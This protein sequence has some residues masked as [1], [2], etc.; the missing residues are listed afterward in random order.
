MAIDQGFANFTAEGFDGGLV[1]RFPAHR[2]G[3]NQSPDAQNF[4]PTEV[5]CVKKRKGF[6]KFTSASTTGNFISG[7]Y[8]ATTSAG[9]TKILASYGTTLDDITAGAFGTAVSGVTITSDA[10]VS[11]KMFND[12]FIIANT[13]GGPYKWSGS[14]SASSLGGSPP[15]N[16]KYGEVH[17]GRFWLSGPGYDYS[18]AA[19]D[20]SRVNGSGLNN[21]ELW[22]TTSNPDNCVSIGFNKGDGYV[23]NG[24]CSAG[25]FMLVSKISNVSG[26][27]EGAIYS[28]FGSS[29]F[30][31]VTKKILSYPALSNTAML[32]YDNFVV[33]ATPKGVFGINGRNPVRMD[34]PIWPTYDAI[35]NKGTIA[36]G[37][38]KKTIRMAYPTSGTTNNAEL[39]LDVERGVWGK[40]TGKAIRVYGNHPDGRLLSGKAGSNV[41]VWEEENGTTDDSAA[42]NFYWETPDIDFGEANEQKRLHSIFTH[43]KNTGSISLAVEQYGDGTSRSLGATMNVSTEGPVKRHEADATPA[44]YHRIRVTNNAASEDVT[45]YRVEAYAEPLQSQSSQ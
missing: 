21:P 31:F 4:D 38:Y 45:L 16:A 19:S 41:L 13:G 44:N 20:P 28:I 24:L 36:L 43:A 5:G 10:M 26:S 11:L 8:G 15:A 7:L 35:P 25:D 9:T 6:I 3:A 37:R 14:G 39:I 1:T 18:A 12:L 34:D 22:D 27:L 40:N 32:A 30:D 29:P 2:L 23:V 33:V 42:I 17:K